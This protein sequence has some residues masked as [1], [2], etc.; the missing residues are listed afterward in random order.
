MT[1]LHL[2]R[3]FSLPKTHL[4]NGMRTLTPRATETQLLLLPM[5]EEIQNKTTWFGLTLKVLP[6]CIKDLN[7]KQMLPFSQ[8]NFVGIITSSPYQCISGMEQ[9]PEKK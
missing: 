5:V 4:V 6:N 9:K 7:G 3:R 8:I 1:W 2:T